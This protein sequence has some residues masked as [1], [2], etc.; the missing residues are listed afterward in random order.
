M[1]VNNLNDCQ[2]LHS[3]LYLNSFVWYFNMIGLSLNIFECTAVTF[4]R[5]QSPTVYYYN[6]TDSVLLRADS[7]V[8]DLGFKFNDSL[9]PDSEYQNTI[10]RVLKFLGFVAKLT[11]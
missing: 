10:R 4:N 9:E 2:K 5:N 7:N 11:N 1:R 8:I 3:D 6:L